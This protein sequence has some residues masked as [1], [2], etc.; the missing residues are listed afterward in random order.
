MKNRNDLER[1]DSACLGV[2]LR[3][4]ADHFSA[5]DVVRVAVG[6]PPRKLTEEID[7]PIWPHNEVLVNSTDRIIERLSELDSLSQDEEGEDE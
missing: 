2:P 7:E 4:P 6:M 1:N 5:S 3:L